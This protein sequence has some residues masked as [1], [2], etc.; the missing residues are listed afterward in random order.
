MRVFEIMSERPR[1]ISSSMKAAAAWDVMSAANIH[2]LI[3]KDGAAVVGVLSDGDLGGPLGGPIREGRTVAAMMQRRF[4][5]VG[6]GDTIRKAAN[7]MGSRGLT[8][9]PVIDRDKLVGVVT[10]ADLLQ[11]LGRG[12]DRPGREDRAALHYRVPH[13]KAAAGTGR[14]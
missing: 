12:V 8:C 10:M 6:P 1:T 4:S 9:L 7:L 2:H 13:K 5:S 14:W 11:L 3:V